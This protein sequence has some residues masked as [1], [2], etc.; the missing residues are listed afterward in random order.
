MKFI[1]KSNVLCPLGGYQNILEE[2]RLT[3]IRC[4]EALY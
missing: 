4:E 3:M 2:S 1:K